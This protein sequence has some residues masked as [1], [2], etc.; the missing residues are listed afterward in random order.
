MQFVIKLL[1]DGLML[2][3]ALL[4]GYA[5]LVRVPKKDRYDRYTRILMAGVTS[6]LVAKYLGAVWQ[7]ETLRPFELSGQIAGAAY[8]NNP[9]FPSDHTLFASFLTLAV[10]YGTRLKWLTILLGVLTVTVAIGRVL[11]LVH[12]PIDVIGGMIIGVLGA[13]WYI[14]YGKIFSQKLVKNTNR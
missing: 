7:P 8:L 4:A 14:A 1:A 11:A 3:I 5:L 10:W 9:G 6:Y 12:T 13:V 2:P